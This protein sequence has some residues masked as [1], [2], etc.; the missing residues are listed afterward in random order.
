[1]ESASTDDIKS[2]Q[3]LWIVVVIGFLTTVLFIIWIFVYFMVYNTTPTHL[4]TITNNNDFNINVL[5]GNEIIDGDNIALTTIG[6]TVLPP[7]ASKNYYATPSVNVTIQA[8]TDDQILPVTYPYPLT[9]TTIRFSG[10][11][12][13]G[14]TYISDGQTILY[15]ERN[16][17]FIDNDIYG[18]SMKDGY[19]LIIN[20]EAEGERKYDDMYSCSGPI[21]NFGVDNCP[22]E[23]SATGN[24]CLNPCYANGTDNYCCVPKSVCGETGGC[25]SSWLDYYNIFYAACNKCLITNCDIPRYHCRSGTTLTS[26]NITFTS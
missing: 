10:I 2:N 12:Y 4:I 7:G 1:M 13:N 16:D 25:Q 3:D 21:W 23:L 20:I 8:Y 5:V 11:T 24:I 15:V 19:N 17:N 18:V 14:R 9:K 22:E 26:Y 6:P